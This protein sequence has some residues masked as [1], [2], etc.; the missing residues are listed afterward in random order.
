[1]IRETAKM[2]DNNNEIKLTSLEK[3]V[4]KKHKQ[5]VTMYELSKKIFY[6]S[7]YLYHILQRAKKKTVKEK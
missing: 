7:D 6:S 2:S 3:L 1:M 5:G 4:L